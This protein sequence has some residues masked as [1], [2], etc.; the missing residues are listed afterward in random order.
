MVRSPRM[1]ANATFALNAVLCVFRVCFIAC[2]HAIG[3]F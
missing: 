3:A 2:S 1:G